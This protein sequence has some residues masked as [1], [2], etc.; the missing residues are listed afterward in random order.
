MMHVQSV[1]TPGNNSKLEFREI[2]QTHWLGA[3]RKTQQNAA[4]KGRKKPPSLRAELSLKD[5]EED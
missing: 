2:R 5:L 1:G 3:V 4:E